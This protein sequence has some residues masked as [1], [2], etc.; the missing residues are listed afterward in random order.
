MR[1]AGIDD[2]FELGV[3]Q[4]AVGDNVRRQMRPIGRL[5]RRDRGHRRGLDELG[6]MRLRA[7][8]TDRLQAIFFIERIA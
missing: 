8:N 4:Q 2:A 7:G 1:L 5:G 6:R 3:R